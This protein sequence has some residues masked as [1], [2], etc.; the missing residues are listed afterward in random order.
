MLN[1][2]DRKNSIDAY[3]Y[4]YYHPVQVRGGPESSIE[5]KGRTIKPN[6]ILSM[7]ASTRFMK[8]SKKKASLGKTLKIEEDEREIEAANLRLA[9]EAFDVFDVNGDGTISK[10]ELGIV[11]RTMGTKINQVWF[12]FSF[13]SAASTFV[14]FKSHADRFLG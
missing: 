11:L 13:L 6:E 2:T 3:L 5:Y 9:R 12:R 8:P 10:G 1:V 4:N 14:N 7:G